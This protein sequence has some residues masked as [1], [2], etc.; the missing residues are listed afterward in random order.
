MH[1]SR[2]PSRHAATLARLKTLAGVRQ[3]SQLAFWFRFWAGT[4]VAPILWFT[5]WRFG[6]AFRCDRRWHHRLVCRLISVAQADSW[7][8]RWSGN[9]LAID[10]YKASLN[11]RKT[12]KAL[13][14]TFR[15]ARLS[16]GSETATAH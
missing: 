3:P 11:Q 4:L 12:L 2:G 10:A 15:A 8:D 1:A 5:G 14:W 6:F 9:R 16:L 13:D 7:A